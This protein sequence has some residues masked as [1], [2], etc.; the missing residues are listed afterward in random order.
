MSG[1]LEGQ[2]ALV[3]GA[4]R[5]IGRAIAERLARDKALVLVNYLQSQA[6][7]EAV[8]SGSSESSSLG[9][10][11]SCAVMRRTPPATVMLPSSSTRSRG[12]R[13]K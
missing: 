7:A 9:G 11:T 4:S 6:A 2:I 12:R 3:T 13:S 5:G 8:V 10:G 1:I